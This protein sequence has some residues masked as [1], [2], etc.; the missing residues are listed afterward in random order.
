MSNTASSLNHVVSSF[1]VTVWTFPSQ[2]GFSTGSF[3]GFFSLPPNFFFGLIGIVKVWGAYWLPFAIGIYA[4]IAL[5]GNGSL[6]HGRSCGIFNIEDWVLVCIVLDK[7][8]L[9][10]VDVAELSAEA[11]LAVVGRAFRGSC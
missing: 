1:D 10:A 2:I 8:A 4:A 6:L 11:S 3:L 7:T 5:C 9:V